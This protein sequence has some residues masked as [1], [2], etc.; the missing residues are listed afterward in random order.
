MDSLH[1]VIEGHGNCLHQHLLTFACHQP[2]LWL[3]NLATDKLQAFVLQRL[4]VLYDEG[5]NNRAI[6]HLLNRTVLLTNKLKS[7]LSAGY[8]LHGCQDCFQVY[9]VNKKGEVR[10]YILLSL[11]YCTKTETENHTMKTQICKLLLCSALRRQVELCC[12]L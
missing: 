5:G 10:G 11:N 2:T 12:I 8:I 3:T 9:S 7:S 6:G 4:S 1:L